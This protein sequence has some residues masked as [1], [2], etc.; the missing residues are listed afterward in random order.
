MMGFLMPTAM[1]FYKV[2]AL[3]GTL[4]IVATVSFS[5]IQIQKFENSVNDIFENIVITQLEVD[6]LKLELEHIDKAL[7]MT[8]EDENGEGV[9]ATAKVPYTDY[10]IQHLKSEKNSIL[11]HIKEKELVLMGSSGMKKHVMNEVRF[12]FVMAFSGLL[13][14]T[15]VAAFGYLGWYFRLEFFEDRRKRRR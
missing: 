7:A 13:I 11:L 6:G 8:P 15:L 1:R 10:E 9:T 5:W 3:L 2:C 14:G 4:F 12:V